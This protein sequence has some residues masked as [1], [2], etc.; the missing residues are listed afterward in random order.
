MR[1]LAS[2]IL[3]IA[4][5]LAV[6]PAQAQTYDSNYPVCIQM[7][8]WGGSD[9]ECSYTSL[10]QCAATA[11]GLSATCSLNPYYAQASKVPYRRGARVY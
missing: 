4:T 2:T 10:A 6:A 8:R 11:S 7:Y 3:A 1:L 5:I 9:I